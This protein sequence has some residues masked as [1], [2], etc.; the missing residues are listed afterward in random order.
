MVSIEAIVERARGYMP[1]EDLAPLIKAHEFATECYSGKHRLSGRPF[2]Y[3]ALMVT[4]ILAAMR[5]DVP[6]LC[7]GL[8]H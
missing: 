5:L 7:A 8:L 3:H 4:D 1:E 2:L 6:T